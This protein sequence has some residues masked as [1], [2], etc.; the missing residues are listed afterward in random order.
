LQIAGII[1]LYRSFRE[2][3]KNL[4]INITHEKNDAL[5]LGGAWIACRSL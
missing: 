1:D 2:V 3:Y 5:R 4:T